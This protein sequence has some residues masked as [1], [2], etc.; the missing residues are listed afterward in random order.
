MSDDELTAAGISDALVRIS[1]GVED[2]RD[3]LKELSEALDAL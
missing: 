3:L 2:R 1:V